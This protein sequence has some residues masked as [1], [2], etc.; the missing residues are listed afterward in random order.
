MRR[1]KKERL[2]DWQANMLADPAFNL[3][4]LQ[5]AGFHLIEQQSACQMI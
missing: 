5:Q 1:N 2:H 4:F 3:S